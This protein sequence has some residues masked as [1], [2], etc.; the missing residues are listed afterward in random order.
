MY[1]K[2]QQM[3]NVLHKKTYFK[4]GYT[5]KEGQ[6]ANGGALKINKDE[7]QGKFQDMAKNLKQILPVMEESQLKLINRYASSTQGGHRTNLSKSIGSKT[8]GN[9]SRDCFSQQAGKRTVS[10][11]RRHTINYDIDDEET[12]KRTDD[13]V[14]VEDLTS[15]ILKMCKVIRGK[16]YGS[17]ILYKKTGVVCGARHGAST[18]HEPTM[19]KNRNKKN[20]TNSDSKRLGDMS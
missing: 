14:S 3:I 20:L 7:L 15:Q 8:W 17:K 4:G 13:T 1:F 12:K 19:I 10:N 2:P 6:Q 5:I 9:K 11:L 18:V 16:N